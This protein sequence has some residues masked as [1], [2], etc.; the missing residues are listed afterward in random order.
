MRIAKVQHWQDCMEHQE[1][2]SSLKEQFQNQRMKKKLMFFLFSYFQ[3][4]VR[5][6]LWP[7]QIAK[8]KKLGGG[9]PSR[10]HGLLLAQYLGEVTSECVQGTIWYWGSNSSFLQTKCMVSLSFLSLQ[11]FKN[12]YMNFMEPKSSFKT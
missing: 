10:T 12:T 2:C 5:V 1:G 6:F 11:N 4:L 9:T 8:K 3:V 7:N